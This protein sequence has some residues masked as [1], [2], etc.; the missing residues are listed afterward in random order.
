MGRGKDAG[1]LGAG[2]ML[3]RQGRVEVASGRRRGG[4]ALRD[5][6][7]AAAAPGRGRCLVEGSAAVQPGRLLLVPPAERP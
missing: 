1:E 2:R 5:A 3:G 7:A 4:G 6:A